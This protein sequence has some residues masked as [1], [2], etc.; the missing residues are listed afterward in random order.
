MSLV[1]VYVVFPDVAEAMR[2]GRTVVEEQLAACINVLAPCTSIYRWQD[3]VE[4]TDEVPALLKSSA[5]AV[6][7]LVAR[8]TEL[9]GYEV[10]AMVAWTADHVPAAVSEWIARSTLVT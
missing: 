3:A 1:V 9:H 7:A 4:Q 8:I 5:G 6:D 10:P 2:I